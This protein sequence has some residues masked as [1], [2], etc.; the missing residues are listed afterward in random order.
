MKL[1]PDIAYIY[2]KPRLD[3]YNVELPNTIFSAEVV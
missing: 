3:R 1:T 2:Q